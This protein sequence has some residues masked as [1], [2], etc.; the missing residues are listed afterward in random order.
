AI[1]PSPPAPLPE[2]AATA[3]ARPELDWLSG[4]ISR[5]VD[6]YRGGIRNANSV[7]ASSAHTEMR[8]SNLR[9][10]HNSRRKATNSSPDAGVGRRVDSLVTSRSGNS[11]AG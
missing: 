2:I 3:V 8:N 9:C 10:P 7:L 1:P 6:S 5:D 4:G 11:G